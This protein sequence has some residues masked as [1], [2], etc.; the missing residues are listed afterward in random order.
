MKPTSPGHLPFGPGTESS[1]SSRNR[2]RLYALILFQFELVVASRGN[3]SLDAD[4]LHRHARASVES[5]PRRLRPRPLFD[6]PQRTMNSAGSSKTLR[7]K[8]VNLQAGGLG[9]TLRSSM[10]ASTSRSTLDEGATW[11][12]SLDGDSE[13]LD[14]VDRALNA[15]VWQAGVDSECVAHVR[16]APFDPRARRL[17]PA[18]ALVLPARGLSSA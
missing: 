18:D 17:T 6:P 4:I 3:R 7:S 9:G 14:E 5:S 11:R 13:P 15:M 16:L 12:S 1:G 10:R 8:L 2:A